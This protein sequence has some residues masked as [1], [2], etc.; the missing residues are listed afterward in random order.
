VEKSATKTFRTEGDYKVQ[1]DRLEDYRTRFRLRI[2]D[3]EHTISDVA[4][5]L[6]HDQANISMMLLR[7]SAR[8]RN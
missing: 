6:Q 7:A 4:K 3:R 8:E 5:F 2:Y 1:L